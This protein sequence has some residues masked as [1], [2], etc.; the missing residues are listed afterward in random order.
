MKAKIVTLEN[1]AAGDITL[2]DA[3]FAIAVR[4][5][6][7]ARMVNWQLAKARAGTHK[8]KGRSEVKGRA[9][10]IGRQKGSGGA[11]HGNH[12]AP[13][14]RGGGV[15][16]GPV[17]RSHA[18]SLPKKIRAF[19]LRSALSLK[20]SQGNYIIL[21]SLKL[22][23]PKTAELRKKLEKLNIDDALIVGGE[24]VDDNF[25]KASNNIPKIDILP[26]QGANVY[27]ILKRKHLI[28]TQD[29]VNYLEQRLS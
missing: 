26:Q 14:F 9:A 2:N 21:E 18:F 4:P 25:A 24:I 22:P 8:V 29:A 6:I 13:Q 28:L 17:V 3:V 10:K 12:K 1:S 15:A 11:R 5:D 27:S 7:M 23:S 19:A 20:V 16:F